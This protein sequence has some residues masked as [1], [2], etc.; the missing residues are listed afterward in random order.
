MSR[1]A[2]CFAVGRPVSMASLLGC[3]PC[4]ISDTT[5]TS[6]K[7][8]WVGPF[9]NLLF[10]RVTG[11]LPA[12]HGPAPP[13]VC[14][15][16]SFRR[17]FSFTRQC[18]LYAWCCWHCTS[19][20]TR[21]PLKL[22]G[23]GAPLFPNRFETPSVVLD[24]LVTTAFRPCECAVLRDS[25]HPTWRGSAPLSWSTC[26]PSRSQAHKLEAHYAALWAQQLSESVGVRFPSVTASESNSLA[27][28]T[29]G[30]L[31]E[32]DVVRWLL[33]FLDS[34]CRS[35]CLLQLFAVIHLILR[36]V[37]LRKGCTTS[38]RHLCR[39]RSL[40]RG[41]PLCLAIALA[42]PFVAGGPLD[43]PAA[44][45]SQP[46]RP[47]VSEAASTG[48]EAARVQG[49]QPGARR[50]FGTLFTASFREP[51]DLE[52]R[53]TSPRS[54][55]FSRLREDG[56][57]TPVQILR[58]QRAPSY[59]V[60]HTATVRDAEDLAEQA[61]VHLDLADHGFCCIP[62]HPQPSL[63]T[64]VLLAAPCRF[65]ELQRIPVC[66]QVLDAHGAVAC[67][68][69]FF[70]PT[71]TLAEVKFVFGNQWPPAARVFVRNSSVPL[72]TAPFS[73][74]AGDL[75][76]V[77][78]PGAPVPEVT[79]VGAKLVQPELHLR[80]LSVE[81]YPTEDHVASRECL[82]QPLCPVQ[83]LMYS[84]VPG[85]SRLQ[86]VVLSH[87]DRNLASPGATAHA[88]QRSTRAGFRC[89]P[90]FWGL[91]CTCFQAGTSVHRRPR[92][93]LSPAAQGLLHWHHAPACL[94]RHRWTAPPRP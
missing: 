93:W 49:G 20:P 88:T 16:P 24:A 42:L 29:F 17:S 44:V 34:F 89:Q 1:S 5:P 38:I 14:A 54:P 57:E 73:L 2:T 66:V 27:N 47:A 31:S 77:V 59:V 74:A 92:R 81:G 87:A 83:L 4:C 84:P 82:L 12:S 48:H 56:W 62:V 3:L 63:D 72:G 75:L 53:Q 55:L 80:R 70:D 65:P 52:A 85:P 8:P 78:R 37:P 45:V 51:V 58:Y 50:T 67:W 76:R 13:L 18:K 86:E 10:C 6:W 22:R 21:Q 7:R 64:L 23:R 15:S 79:T 30:A 60:L 36:A 19:A 9:L 35:F 46:F 40:F 90:S 68:S 41:A 69:E 26:S 28:P 32:T 11:F 33:P 43:R 94:P 25:S 39:S 91:S 61:E 71:I